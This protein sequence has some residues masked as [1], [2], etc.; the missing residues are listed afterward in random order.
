MSTRW[1]HGHGAATTD[2]ASGLI[3]ETTTVWL[4]ITAQSVSPYP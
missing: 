3:A 4:R 2:I 1:A